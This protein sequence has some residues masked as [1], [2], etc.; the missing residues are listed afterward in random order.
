MLVYNELLVIFIAY[1]LIP[2]YHPL[3]NIMYTDNLEEIVLL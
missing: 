2:F 3:S 1:K